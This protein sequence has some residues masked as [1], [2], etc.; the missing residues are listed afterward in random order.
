M[1]DNYLQFSETLDDLTTEQSAWLEEQLQ[2]VVAFG[3]QEFSEDDPAIAKLPPSDPDYTGP[4][5]LRDNPDFDSSWD[6]LGFEFNFINDHGNGK[7]ATRD[8]WL[9]ADTYG[10]PAHVAWLIQKFLKQF[11]PGQCWSLTYANTCSKP[12][13]GEFSGGAV[14]VTANEI[15]QQAASDFIEQERAEFNVTKTSSVEAA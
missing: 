9:F 12:R 14:F 5:F 8:L 4:R 10:D 15:K 6:V 1:A 2:P 3:D 11:R 13:V 7:S